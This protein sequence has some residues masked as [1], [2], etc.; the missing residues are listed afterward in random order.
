MFVAFFDLA[1]AVY[2]MYIYVCMLYTY[3]STH[4]HITYIHTCI[5]CMYNV[6]I[7]LTYIGPGRVE[8]V[9]VNVSVEEERSQMKVT[10]R[11]VRLLL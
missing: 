11:K 9:D 5:T 7:L 1:L 4:I 10:L 6:Y 3:I 2:C 8:I